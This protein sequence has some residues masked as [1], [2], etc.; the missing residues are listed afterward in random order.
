MRKALRYGY[1]RMR[2]VPQFGSCL[3]LSEKALSDKGPTANH[4]SQVFWCMVF[5]FKPRTKMPTTPCSHGA[6]EGPP[7]FL[8]HADRILNDRPRHGPVKERKFFID[9]RLVHSIIEMIVVDQPCAM[10]VLIL[11]SK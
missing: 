6:R 8:V 3:F 5:N 9:N 11:F 2:E 7:E 1:H 4:G 10:E